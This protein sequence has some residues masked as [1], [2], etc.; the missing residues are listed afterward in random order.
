MTATAARLARPNGW[1]GMAIFVATEA[2]LFGTLV[3]TWIYLSLQ[4]EHWPPPQLPKPP[5]LTP[6]LLTLV[7]LGTSGA[8]QLGW[9]SAREWRRLR[10]CALVAAAL[11]LQ[12]F[13]LGWQL[14]D[15][16][17]A[18]DVYRPRESAFASMYV[19]LLG[20]DHLHVIVGALLD[21]WLVLRL[22]TRLT[23]YR[24]VALQ[25]ITFYTHAVNVITVVV[26]IVQISPRL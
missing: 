16:V 18:F 12:V 10:A 8:M 23:R 2:T 7:L 15:Y 4:D 11:A 5:V 25:S 13:Y 21:S 1:W 22:A 14:H 19:T 20:A 26:L 17:H 6:T 9:R 24:L 3:G